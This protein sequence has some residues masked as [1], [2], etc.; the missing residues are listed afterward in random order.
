MN[1]RPQHLRF[2]VLLGVIFSSALTVSAD[3]Q[4]PNIDVPTQPLLAQ[5][6]RLSEALEVVGRP[7]DDASLAELAKAK[8][9]E[10]PQ[11]VT[12][13]VQRIFDPLCLAIVDVQE[14][15]PPKVTKATAKPELLEQGWRTFLVKV[16]NRHGRTGRLFVESPNARPLPYA[17]LN[18]VESRWMQISS[19][20]GQPMRANLSGLALEYRI[21]Q[22][23][24]RDAGQK[25]ALLEFNVSGDPKGD[26]D[27]IREWRF[28]KDTDG[29]NEMNQISIE[30][31]NGSLEV[32][33][34][35]EDPFMGA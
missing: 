1:Y 20:E 9:L 22:I 4:M 10:S 34:T 18:E 14:S 6:H 21:V 3:E 15:G 13:A 30:A 25:S 12:K 28:D 29:W 27:L 17:P 26:R 5:V 35:G 32:E 2:L 11:L 24:S 31:K 8:Q 16:I 23:Y 7:L 33:S 19:F